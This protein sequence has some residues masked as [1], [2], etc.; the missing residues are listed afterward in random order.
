MKYGWSLMRDGNPTR[1]STGT[2][3]IPTFSV[4]NT[5]NTYVSQI[6]KRLASANMVIKIYGHEIHVANMH[7]NDRAVVY[8]W[9][10][11]LEVT[12]VKQAYLNVFRG[13]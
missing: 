2:V 10:E 3:D 13:L 1:D 8:T 6:Q 5:I 9:D 12:K 4:D 7:D 11:V